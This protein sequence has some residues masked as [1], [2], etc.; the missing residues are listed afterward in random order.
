MIDDS[1]AGTSSFFA[2]EWLTARR[3][4]IGL[5][6]LVL[7]MFP[8]IVSGTRTF[9]FRDFSIFGYSWASYH[10]AAFWEGSVPLWNPLN[11]SGIPFL[12]QWNTM[13][14]YPLSIIYLLLPISLSLGYF[15]LFHLWLGGVGMFVLARRWTDSQWASAFAGIAFAFSGLLLNSLSW[16]NNI[17]ALGWMPWVVWLGEEMRAGMTRRGMMAP[18][19]GAAQMLAGAPEV[20]FLTWILISV[21]WLQG[22]ISERETR[23]RILGRFVL[24]AGLVGAL[25]AAQL[26]PFLDLLS[27]SQRDSNYGQGQ[28]PMPLWGLANFFV[29]MFFSFPFGAD[30]YFQPNQYWTTSYYVGIATI[31]FAGLALWKPRGRWLALVIVLAVSLLLAMGEKAYLFEWLRKVAPVFGIMRYPIKFIVLPEFILPLLAALA[32][33]RVAQKPNP[34]WLASAGIVGAGVI[35]ILLCVARF[36][37]LYDDPQYNRWPE[38][39]QNGVLR[40]ALLM[41]LIAALWALTK[42]R[43]LRSRILL[44]VAALFCL[45]LDLRT[46]VPLQNPI[47]DRSFYDSVDKDRNWEMPQAGASRAMPSPFAESTLHNKPLPKPE[48][49]FLRKRLGL[50]CNLN[51]IEGVPKVNGVYSLHLRHMAKVEEALYSKTEIPMPLVD[52]LNVEYITTPR[53][54]MDWQRRTNFMPFISSGQRPVFVADAEALRL[55]QIADFTPREIVYLPIGT[56]LDATNLVRAEF[57]NQKF[58]ANKI[59]FESSASSPA[60]AVI[61]QAYYHRWQPYVDGQRVSLLRANAAFQAVE[62]PAGSHKVILRYEDTYFISGCVIS[63]IALGIWSF[64]FWRGKGKTPDYSGV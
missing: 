55:V 47:I 14:L 11:N 15:C 4:A 34:R 51:L 54:T 57:T 13:T 59:E 49:D 24:F 17:A 60:L 39:L 28:W 44:S 22:W 9:F 12:A 25:C 6:I 31:V 50:Y 53:T 36:K 38:T 35:L 16:P 18:L 29:P 19:A 63:G 41:A 40:G 8:E 46:H 26:L 10:R 62:I 3:F 20:T 23:L 7:A 61:S 5:A 56:K 30:V 2:D 42:M 43:Q 64:L 33:A 32:L 21:L 45:W 58:S 37:P 52:F 1:K 27:H 48:E